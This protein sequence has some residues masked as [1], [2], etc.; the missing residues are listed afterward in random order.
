MTNAEAIQSLQELRALVDI[1][2]DRVVR[3]LEGQAEQIPEPAVTLPVFFE[4]YL[5]AFGPVKQKQVQPL[6]FLVARL[7]ESKIPLRDAAYILATVKHETGDTYLPVKEAYWI[8]DAE[9]WRKKNLP[10]WPWYGRGFVQMTWERNYQI[11]GQKLGLDLTTDPDVVMEP[12][13]SFKILSRGMR[14]GWFTGK[15]LSDYKAYKDMRRVVNGTDKADKIA[16][17]AEKFERI[18]KQVW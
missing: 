6:E 9:A 8:E 17:Y 3:G 12:E 15:K 18:L 16:E 5:G 11:A 1:V 4:G 14:E 10:Y 7:S 2:L 13:T